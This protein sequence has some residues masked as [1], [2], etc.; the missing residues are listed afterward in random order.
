MADISKKTA[1]L[2]AAES[3]M[4]VKGKRARISEIASAAGVNDSVIYHYFKNKEDLLFSVAEER[5]IDVR[6]EMDEQLSGIIDPVS[7]LRK[8][9]WFRLNYIDK[10]RDYGEL[11]MFE[12]RSNINFFKH[13]AIHQTRWFLAK[14]GEIVEQGMRENVFSKGLNIWLVRDIV[15][16]IM[17]LTNI[18]GL[19]GEIESATED[20]DAIMDFL[21]QM[22]CD[23][24]LPE[25]KKNKKYRILNAA[26][27][28]FSE[29]GY[30]NAKIQDIAG[31]AGIA[32][33]TVYEY[34][35]NKED[36]LFSTL[37]EGFQ[38]SILKSGFQDHLYSVCGI[39]DAA[40]PI[41][42]LKRFI[43]QHF[44]IC[45]TQPSFVKLFILNGVFNRQFY[46]K[47]NVYATFNNYMEGVYSILDEGKKEGLVRSNVNNR[48]FRNLIIGAFSHI[49]LRWMFAEEKT[50]L[51]KVEEINEMV[52]MLIRSVISKKGGKHFL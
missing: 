35:N 16:G 25:E 4:A 44:L 28:I 13:S 20:F 10:N 26:E 50:R 41:D 31:A 6:R 39:P 9:V 14:L 34:F 23:S 43:R 27:Q 30:E 52:S 21:L 47:Q 7:K 11:L 8:L 33:G 32:D 12:C 49:T 15:F 24:K 38:P 2:K 48:I 45:L 36:L 18:Q 19:L 5:L 46:Q 37:Q 1:I 22:M 3:I 29:K 51:N 17:D 42:K 40:T